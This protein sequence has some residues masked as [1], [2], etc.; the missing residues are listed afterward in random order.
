MVIFAAVSTVRNI[1][2]LAYPDPG[3]YVYE[4]AYG[5][6][7]GREQLDERDRLERAMRDSQRHQAILSLVG[8]GTM[9]LLAGPA[10]L[11]HWRRVQSELTSP[12]AVDA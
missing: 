6:R 4:P 3:S 7:G 12:R 9:L 10:Y 11:Y 1:V 8:S 2:Q 5:P